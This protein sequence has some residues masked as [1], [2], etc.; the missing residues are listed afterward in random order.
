MNI[1]PSF[2]VIGHYQASLPGN[3]ETPASHPAA[4]QGPL[5]FQGFEPPVDAADDPEQS[6]AA[7]WDHRLVGTSHVRIVM[8]RMEIDALVYSILMH[9]GREVSQFF[10]FPL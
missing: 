6:H 4:L 7:G 3:L 8:K 5:Q 1:I 9:V 2:T 10:H